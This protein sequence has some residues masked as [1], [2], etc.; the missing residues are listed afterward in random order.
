[1]EILGL[2]QRSLAFSNAAKNRCSYRIE[3]HLV[4]ASA[5]VYATAY[6]YRRAELSW[7]R[8]TKAIIFI[9]RSFRID[10]I[11][12]DRNCKLT[13]VHCIAKKDLLFLLY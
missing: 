12:I 9:F 13:H 7:K 1:M 4:I 11:L 10:T 8:L 2:F 3:T 6:A 5:S